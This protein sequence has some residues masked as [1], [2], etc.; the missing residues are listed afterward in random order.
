MRYPAIF[1]SGAQTQ[2][3]KTYR[4]T[5][6]ATSE[7]YSFQRMFSVAA[8]GGPM[9]ATVGREVDQAIIRAGPNPVFIKWRRGHGVYDPALSWL[10]GRLGTKFP[11]ARR[12]IESFAR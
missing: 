2:L 4:P 9:L 5:V 11:D 10:G 6:R 1:A 7:K 3:S 8:L 12:D